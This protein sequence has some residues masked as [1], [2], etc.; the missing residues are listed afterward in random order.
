MEGGHT[1]SKEGM[2]SVNYLRDVEHR[3]F[4][5]CPRVKNAAKRRAVAATRGGVTTGNK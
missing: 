4:R 5:H 2:T 1:C 3:S